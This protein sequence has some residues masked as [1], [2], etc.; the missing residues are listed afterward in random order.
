MDMVSQFVGEHAV[1]LIRSKGFEKGIPQQDAAGLSHADQRSIGSPCPPTHIEG[2]DALHSRPG[3]FR[4]FEKS[5]H[6]LMIL[7]SERI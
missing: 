6:K 7:L 1:N 4:K 2:V 5:F 3:L